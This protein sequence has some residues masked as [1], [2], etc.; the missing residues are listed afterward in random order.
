MCVK[1]SPKTSRSDTSEA[2]M[3]HAKNT[4][5]K[6]TQDRNRLL[7]A[8][9]TVLA[10]AVII[11]FCNLLPQSAKSLHLIN[12]GVDAFYFADNI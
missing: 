2:A 9:R 4:A 6:K 3:P 5:D 10:T 7:Q 12:T 11:I 1:F 8:L